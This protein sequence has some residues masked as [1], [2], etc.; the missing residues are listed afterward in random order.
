MQFGT[1]A[2]PSEETRGDTRKP[3]RC[4]IKVGLANGAQV[5]GR[6]VDISSSGIC[7]M[8][9]NSLPPGQ[10]CMIHFETVIGGMQRKVEAPAKVV[11]NIYGSAGFR[12]GFRFVD[13]SPNNSVVV[14]WL[15]TS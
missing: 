15:V 12:T 3:F 10:T 2:S 13:L 9:G 1:S 4:R 14:N 8:V 6:T 7:V 11:Y 5:E